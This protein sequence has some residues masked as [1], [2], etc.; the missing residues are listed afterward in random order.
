MASESETVTIYCDGACSGNQFKG[1]RGGWGAVLSYRDAG[2]EIRGGE[3]NTTNQR[4]ELM[5]CIA[6]L[7][8]LKGDGLDVVAVSYTHL[9]LPTKRIV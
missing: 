6:A 3:K 7:E 8:R 2:K 5:A 4:M 1:N 9:T